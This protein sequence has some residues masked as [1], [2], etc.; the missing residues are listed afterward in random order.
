MKTEYAHDIEKP[1]RGIWLKRYRIHGAGL[2]YLKDIKRFEALL[3]DSDR[4][5]DT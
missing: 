4:Y 5:A 2:R 3:D 1:R